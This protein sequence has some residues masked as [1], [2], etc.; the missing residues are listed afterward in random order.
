MRK[1]KSN[2]HANG[3]LASSSSKC[4]SKRLPFLPNAGPFRFHIHMPLLQDWSPQC[5]VGVFLYIV[6]NPNGVR[7]QLFASLAAREV[8]CLNFFRARRMNVCLLVY[9]VFFCVYTFIIQV[10]LYDALYCVSVTEESITMLSFG[11]QPKQ[12]FINRYAVFLRQPSCIRC[13]EI[14]IKWNWNIEQDANYICSID[15]T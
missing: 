11:A 1:Q 8:R 9:K 14:A 15:Q 5:W 3:L 6:I 10:A 7:L 4:P 2:S 12:T 13:G